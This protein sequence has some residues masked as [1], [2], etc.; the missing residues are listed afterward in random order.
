M[1]ARKYHSQESFLKNGFLLIMG[2]VFDDSAIATLKFKYFKIGVM[3]FEILWV[4]MVLDIYI[5]ST[6]KY[7]Y[8]ISNINNHIP[9]VDSSLASGF[10]TYGTIRSDDG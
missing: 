4:G 9:I 1:K 2:N 5:K 6:I 8:I 3:Y 10:I 7:L